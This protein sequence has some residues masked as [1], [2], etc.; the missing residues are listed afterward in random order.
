MVLDIQ[1]S[2]V[3]SDI[4]NF[5]ELLAISKVIKF[6][7]IKGINLTKTMIQNYSKIGLLPPLIDKR[8]Y[9]RNHL[10]RIYVIYIL[11]NS[12]SLEEIGELFKLVDNEA[13]LITLYEDTLSIE[14]KLIDKKEELINE[15]NDITQV[16]S[17]NLFVKRLTKMKNVIYFKNNLD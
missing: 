8:Y 7:E 15:I 16:V 14:K 5:K 2:N 9:G 1:E 10:V 17:E 3:F 6:F 13:D 11:K 12:F 4:N